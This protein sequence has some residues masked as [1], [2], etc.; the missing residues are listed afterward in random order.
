M[1]VG[2]NACHAKYF[3]S[4]LCETFNTFIT[5]AFAI[6]RTSEENVEHHPEKIFLLYEIRVWGRSANLR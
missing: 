5:Y 2:R 6:S 4:K 3:G 1:Y